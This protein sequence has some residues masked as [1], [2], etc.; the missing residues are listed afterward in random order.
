[1][2]GHQDSGASPCCL[3][4]LRCHL[5][6]PCRSGSYISGGLPSPLQP[7]LPPVRKRASAVLP[8]GGRSTSRTTSSGFRPPHAGQL[9]QEGGRARSGRGKARRRA[10]PLRPIPS[11]EPSRTLSSCTRSRFPLRSRSPAGTF[12]LAHL[13]C[14]D[15]EGRR[16]EVDVGSPFSTHIAPAQLRVLIRASPLGR[17]PGK[18]GGAQPR[19]GLNL[20][21]GEDFFCCGVA[22]VAWA[23][24]DGKENS[25]CELSGGDWR[26]GVSC[27]REIS[28]G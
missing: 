15:L 8:T 13:H 20:G 24:E 28:I 26:T 21:S 10:L 2:A 27:A 17:R 18:G 5:A 25:W 11:L 12:A 1:V 6:V 23:T 3:L 7:D 14:P 22:L 9:P 16:A 19:D 4:P